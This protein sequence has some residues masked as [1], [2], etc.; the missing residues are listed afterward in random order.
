M[1]TIIIISTQQNFNL[2]K[3]IYTLYIDIY[4]IRKKTKE[5]NNAKLR[6]VY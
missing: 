4:K 3:F 1:Q 2:R 6:Q 5:T